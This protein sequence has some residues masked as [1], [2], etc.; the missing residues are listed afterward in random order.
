MDKLKYPEIRHPFERNRTVTT[1]VGESMT[2]QSF[3]DECD[4]NTITAQYKQGFRPVPQPAVFADLYG[5]G[6]YMDALNGTIAAR[7]AF[8]ELPA[9]TRARFDNDP[10]KMLEFLD[11]ERNV[12][13]AR[14]LGLVEP[15]ADQGP[16]EPVVDQE[17]PGLPLSEGEAAT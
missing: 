3:K 13:E 5:A 8:A 16:A 4:I 10:A 6:E 7:E 14:A 17:E 2:H 15:V 9:S 11:D 12:E 1:V